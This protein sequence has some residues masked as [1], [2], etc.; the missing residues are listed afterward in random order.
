MARNARTAQQFFDQGLA[1]LHSFE[2]LDARNHFVKAQQADPQCGMAYWGELMAYNHPLF[3][4]HR[5][6]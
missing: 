2:Y 3:N 4:R 1:Y 5:T 6:T